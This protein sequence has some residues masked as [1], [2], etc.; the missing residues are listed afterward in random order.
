M[1]YKATIARYI[2]Y[3]NPSTPAQLEECVTKAKYRMP[4]EK[5]KNEFNIQFQLLDH[6]GGL[7]LAKVASLC[8][9]QAKDGLLTGEN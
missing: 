4:V 3:K 8:K 1:K 7:A 9:L 5:K 2:F 6:Q